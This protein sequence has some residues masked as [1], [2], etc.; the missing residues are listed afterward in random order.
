[1]RADKLKSANRF[2]F[3]TKPR[4]LHTCNTVGCGKQYREFSG[5]ALHCNVHGH[6]LP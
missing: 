5:L 6:R 1:M 3:K 2:R 4:K